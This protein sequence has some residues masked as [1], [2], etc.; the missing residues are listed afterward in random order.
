MSGNT[1]FHN[2]EIHLATVYYLSYMETGRRFQL[3]KTR[4][5]VFNEVVIGIDATTGTFIMPIS[6]C[7][8]L[9]VAMT[10]VLIFTALPNEAYGG[11]HP[12]NYGRQAASPTL[13]MAHG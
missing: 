10:I 12:R 8:Y 1:A 5:I 2:S 6:G 13:C 4:D 11:G 7:L 3:K 9:L